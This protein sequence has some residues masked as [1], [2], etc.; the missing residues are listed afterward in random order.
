MN[1]PGINTSSICVRRVTFCMLCADNVA[2]V[3]RTRLLVSTL[4]GESNVRGLSR[5]VLGRLLAQHAVR[6]R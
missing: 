3:L 4:L 5:I 6:K 2:V 1:A